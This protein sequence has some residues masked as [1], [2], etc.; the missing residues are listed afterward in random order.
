MA[1]FGA[2]SIEDY[3]LRLSAAKHRELR[4]AGTGWSKAQV[5]EIV[6]AIIRPIVGRSDYSDLARFHQ[7]LGLG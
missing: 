3:V 2:G 1:G 6:R 7:D 5:R 4:A